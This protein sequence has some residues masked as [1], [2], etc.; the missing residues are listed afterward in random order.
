MLSIS[1]YLSHKKADLMRIYVH[2]NRLIPAILYTSQ[3]ACIHE[4][5]FPA[6][7]AETMVAIPNPLTACRNKSPGTTDTITQ[8]P[9]YAVFT[10]SGS[11]PDNTLPAVP[12]SL[13]L[14]RSS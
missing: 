3:P 2:M 6:K 7:T 10:V 9:S 13:P 8:N 11:Q 12:L 1:T 4:I 14:I 5:L